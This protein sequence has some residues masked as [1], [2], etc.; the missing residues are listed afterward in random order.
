MINGENLLNMINVKNE[1]DSS[2]LVP[3]KLT[4]LQTNFLTMTLHLM[5]MGN[6]MAPSAA[7]AKL[8]NAFK[9]PVETLTL[10]EAK[11]IHADLFKV[12]ASMVLGDLDGSALLELYR[13]TEYTTGAKLY[14]KQEEIRDAIEARFRL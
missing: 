11:T 12:G 10:S 1:T 6:K 8:D 13:G 7:K 2:Q 3:N 9:K 5:Q 4:N 14:K